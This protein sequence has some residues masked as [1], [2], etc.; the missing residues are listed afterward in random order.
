M[1]LNH[2]SIIKF[3]ETEDGSDTFGHQLTNIQEITSDDYDKWD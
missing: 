3:L 2:R 1:P